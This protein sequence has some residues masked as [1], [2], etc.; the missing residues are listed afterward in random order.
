[1]CYF[2]KF[3][4]LRVLVLAKTASLVCQNCGSL[5]L[6]LEMGFTII[7]IKVSVFVEQVSFIKIYLED[8]DF[9][10]LFVLPTWSVVGKASTPGL[11]QFEDLARS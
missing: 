6:I 5:K 9:H 2:C 7:Y 8:S 1:M 11:D 3:V 4:K 10:R